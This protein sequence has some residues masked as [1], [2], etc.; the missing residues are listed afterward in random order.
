MHLLYPVDVWPGPWWM[1]L[2]P[3]HAPQY[4]SLYALG[5][6]TSRSRWPE[7]CPDSL[8]RRCLLVVAAA[9]GACAV[10]RLRPGREAVW[11]AGGGRWQTFAGAAHE[12]VLCGA[13]GVD[14]SG[15]SGARCGKEA[16]G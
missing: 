6:W 14:R 13:L 16:A 2:E 11:L 4:L 1:P 7:R 15:S 10:Y 3:A 8:G 9:V 12:A 5:V